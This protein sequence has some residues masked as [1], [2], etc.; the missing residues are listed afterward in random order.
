MLVGAPL[1]VIS[2]GAEQFIAGPGSPNGTDYYKAFQA[3]GYNVVYNKTELLATGNDKK[4]LGIFSSWCLA[5]MFCSNA[6][7]SPL[8]L[9]IC[10]YSKLLKVRV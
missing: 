9:A 5:L 7:L 6:Y 8:Q 3:A 2:G 10:K 1:I 4:T